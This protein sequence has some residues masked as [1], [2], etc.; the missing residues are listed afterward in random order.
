MAALPVVAV[1]TAKT[2]AE[3][4]VRNA[5][6]E[7]VTASRAEEG[8]IEYSLFEVTDSPG[9]FVTIEAWR[10]QGDLDAHLRAP[11]MTAALE[12]AGDEL[13]TTPSIYALAPVDVAAREE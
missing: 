8:C 11:H 3:D 9:V 6:Q 5:L 2:G 1:I 13:V 12:A 4:T 7:L 10:E